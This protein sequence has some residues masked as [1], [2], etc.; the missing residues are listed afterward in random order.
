MMFFD[1]LENIDALFALKYVDFVDNERKQD[2]DGQDAAKGSHPRW[3]RIFALI[4]THS[5]W[6]TESVLVQQLFREIATILLIDISSLHFN[7]N[8]QKI[9]S[10]LFFKL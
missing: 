7:T 2:H 3:K 9:I 5:K 6:L 10:L 4:Q 8:S 1:C